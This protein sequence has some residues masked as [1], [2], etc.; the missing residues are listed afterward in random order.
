M[1]TIL[2]ELPP[3]LLSATP[4][5]LHRVLRGPTLIHL[6]GRRVAPLFVSVLLHG[7]EYTGLEAVQ[8]LLARYRDRAL[9]RALSLFVGNV[10]AAARGE[11]RLDGQPDYNRVWPGADTGRLPEHAMMREVVEQMRARNVFASI[12]IHNN[13]GLNP[14]YGCV[15][16]L[17]HSTL[18]LAVLFSRIVVFFQRPLGVQSMAFSQLCPAVTVE[19][20]KAGERTGAEHAAAFVDAALHLDHFP[21]HPVTRHDVDLYRTVGIV[22]V[23]GEVSFGFGRRDV[24]LSFEPDL[25]R[26][27][28]RELP[29]GTRIAQVN[30]ACAQALKICDENGA[31]V[32]ERYFE[33]IGGELRTRQRVTP[34]MLTLDERIIRQDCLCYL[35]E[36]CPLPAA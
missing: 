26:M 6:P 4:A 27:N 14:H 28:F 1:L 35:M 19:C 32:A 10:A 21:E 22:Q 23:S 36:R 31:E 11:R 9:P 25:D 16:R 20:G 29:S 8:A 3:Q 18:H 7:S 2:T 13:T 34:A 17:D 5:E 24:D 15:N 33:V 30:R 12:D